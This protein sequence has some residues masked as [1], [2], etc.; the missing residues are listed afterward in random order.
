MT[1]ESKINIDP[2]W[3][4]VVK[5]GGLSLSVAGAIAGL[6]IISVLISQQ[7]LPLPA[8]DTLENPAIPFYLFLS[9]AV[10]ELLL[11]PG[12]FALY[13][14]IKDIKKAPAFIACAFML[15]CVPMFL[16]SRGFIFA[17][18]QISDN[19]LVTTNE[20]MRAAYIAA[21]ELA[22]ETQS[23]YSTMALISLC[24]AS[25][26]IGLVIRKGILGKYI[27]YL[28]ITAGVLTLFSPFVV[29]MGIPLIIPFI[30]LILMGYWQIVIGARLF[31]LGKDV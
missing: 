25:I 5:W 2:S 19:Y 23:M 28:V 12:A 24:V 31:K 18:A 3:K 14:T 27:G 16:A 17:I 1:Q 22:I 8:K 13:F 30:G 21:T 6:F 4:N 15:L 10:G 29:M 7:T 11:M 26:I 9:V 20:T